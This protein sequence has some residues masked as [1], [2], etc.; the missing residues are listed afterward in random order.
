V[1]VAQPARVTPAALAQRVLGNLG[2]WSRALAR[3]PQAQP[4]RPGASAIAATALTVAAIVASMFFLDVSASNWARHLPP[5]VTAAFEQITDF[6]LSGW[7]LYPL[8][9]ILLVLAALATPELPRRAQGV[10]AALAAQYGFLFVAIAAPGLFVTISKRLI[11]RARPFV[12]GHDDPF[13]YMPFI[14]QPAYAS[15]PSGHATTAAAAAVAIGSVWPR[16]RG[17][18]WLYALII[19]C[20]RVVVLAHHPSDVLAG[21]LVG[22]V[23]ALLVRRWFA[24]RGLGFAIGGDGR[25]RALPGPSPRRIKKV[26][27]RIIAG[28]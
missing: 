1:T 4:P 14:W 17:V 26:A 15:M 8:G 27:R 16:L 21:A 3:A 22:V 7:F 9:F 28:A 11:G 19:M 10:L 24:A 23:G 5:P 20:S 18:M 13:A 25:M 12:G 2:R 6:G